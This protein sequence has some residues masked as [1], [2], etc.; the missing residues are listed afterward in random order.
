MTSPAQAATTST[1]DRLANCESGGN[2]HINT[3]NGYY[4]GVQFSDGT[5]DAYGGE[6]FASRADLA[7]KS[8]QITIAEKLLD[9]R[10]WS[11]WPACSSRLGLSSA[12][13]KG[14][15]DGS[16]DDQA[17]RG[18]GGDSKSDGNAK[19]GNGD[20][21][22]SGGAAE[23]KAASSDEPKAAGSD[24]AENAGDRAADNRDS[25]RPASRSGSRVQSTNLSRG[26]HR[27]AAGHDVYIVRR[28]DT[29]SAIANAKNIPGGWQSLYRTNRGVV[30]SNPGLIHP[31]LR[32]N[33]G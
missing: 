28:G 31:G 1:W 22:K 13:A 20:N 15:P 9:A 6:K 29:L 4:G 25:A 19:A 7:S 2:W 11:P 18:N 26:K 14:S 23:T 24:E 30:G 21:A 3:G 33:I 10:G 12:D 8:E 5:W 27:K 16:G 32:L 17:G